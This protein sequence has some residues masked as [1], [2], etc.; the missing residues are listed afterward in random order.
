MKK[1][2]FIFVTAFVLIFVVSAAVFLFSKNKEEAKIAFNADQ[3]NWQQNGKDGTYIVKMKNNNLSSPVK[4]K[5]LND[6][7]C[8]PDSQGLSHCNVTVTSPDGKQID[9]EM[10]HNMMN[11]PCLDLK[12]TVE[13]SPYT[14]GYAK[15]KI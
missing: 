7:N 1:R 2:I 4:V 8:D 15:V 5:V 13:L 11:F 14:D 9:F 10:T 12:S 6:A 3:F